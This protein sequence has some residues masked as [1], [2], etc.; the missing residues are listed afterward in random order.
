MWESKLS[1]CSV[2]I[3]AIIS[4]SNV[5]S[6]AMLKIILVSLQVASSFKEAS[7]LTSTS[8]LLKQESANWDPNDN[9]IVQETRKMADT[10]YN[11]TQYL[12]NRGPILVRTTKGYLYGFCF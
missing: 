4:L 7:A 5:I 11:M 9:K 6:E 3:E 8:F 10:L 2:Y 1:I 12:R